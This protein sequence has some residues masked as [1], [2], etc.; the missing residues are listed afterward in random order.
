MEKRIKTESLVEATVR[1]SNADD[2]GREY[3][4]TADVRVSGG[5]VTGVANGTVRPSDAA[6]A[7]AGTFSQ[8]EGGRMA[9]EFPYGASAEEKLGMLEAMEGFI[10]DCKASQD[11]V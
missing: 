11:L 5:R 10:A 1:V 2:A 8:W 9:A 6:G 7:E 4:M 3:D